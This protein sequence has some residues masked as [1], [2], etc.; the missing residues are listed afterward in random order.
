MISSEFNG[1]EEIARKD[2]YLSINHFNDT[3]VILYTH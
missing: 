2:S 3:L 1:D